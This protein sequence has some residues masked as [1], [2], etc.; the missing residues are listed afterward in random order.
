M[1]D[2]GQKR[3]SVCEACVYASCE[4]L[5]Y[6]GREKGFVFIPIRRQFVVEVSASAA[7]QHLAQI[8]R[9]PTWA[10]HIRRIELFPE[11]EITQRSSGTIH[12]RN[13]VRSTFHMT[14]FNPG[15][16]WKWIGPFL[17]LTV[18]YD[19]R[20]EP[21][22][23]AHTKLTWIVGL[24]GFGATIIGRIFA[25]VYERNLDRVIPHLIRELNGKKQTNI[26]R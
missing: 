20:F 3:Q 5:S 13:G 10:K 1:R 22:D 9:W 23:D 21:I 7:W 15:R 26:G 16:N 2:W 25:K 24:T 14:E 12:L 19:H 8:S 17:W 11:G 18:H 6:K 4:R